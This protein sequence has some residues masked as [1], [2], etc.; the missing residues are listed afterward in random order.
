MIKRVKLLSAAVVSAM[1]FAGSAG[2]AMAV[3]DECLLNSG[4]FFVDPYDN[5]P[6]FWVCP[7]PQIYAMCLSNPD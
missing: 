3:G 2:S 1:A 4:C 7:N 5:S 6:G